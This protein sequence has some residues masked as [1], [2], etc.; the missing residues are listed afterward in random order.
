MW[1]AG[2]ESD[3]HAGSWVSPKLRQQRRMHRQPPCFSLVLL[4][5]V[6]TRRALWYAPEKIREGIAVAAV[7]GIDLGLSSV[8]A[9]V[10]DKSGRLL[11]RGRSELAPLT[12]HEGREERDPDDWTRACTEAVIQARAESCDQGIEAIGIGGLGPCPVLV[13]DDNRPI[14]TSPLFSL[15]PRA[16]E[17]RLGLIR[18]HKLPEH[19]LGPDHVIPRLMQWR[20]QRPEIFAKAKRVLDSTGYLVAGLTGRAV[21]DP[22]TLVDHRCPGL[23][24]PVT[25]PEICPADVIAG[26][27]TPRAAASLAMPAGTPVTVGTYD[28]YA[29][30]LGTG[31]LRQGDCALLLGTTMM[32]GS[33]GAKALDPTLPP[34]S[35]LRVTPHVGEG[36]LVGGWTSSAGSLLDW[37]SSILDIADP[38]LVETAM[39]GAAGLIVLPYFAGERAPVWD[40]LAR[41]VI[42]GATLSTTAE[43]F[44]RAMLDGVALSLLDLAH[45]LFAVNGVPEKVRALGGGLKSSVWS[46]AAADAL[47]VPMEAID[48]AGEAIGPV[49]LAWRAIGQPQK[50]RVSAVIMPDARRHERYQRLAEIYRKLYPALK[51]SM[52]KLGRLAAETEKAA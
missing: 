51:E 33:V 25:L 2:T 47:G 49:A 45:R 13:D 32:L 18:D 12:G 3:K 5:G 36:P 14:T 16:E 41:G 17:F 35:G 28:S 4:P 7:L 50:P 19:E 38:P 15:D 23:E 52:H 1:R 37:S 20:M 43:E 24:Q 8:R 48:H 31:T 10:V 40:P 26:H 22:I 46:Q 6:V 11:G 27:L 39:P 44:K 29:D 34:R 9:A 42:L 30:I 21:M